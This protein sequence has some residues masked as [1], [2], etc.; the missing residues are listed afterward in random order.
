[1][2]IVSLL[3][4]A[5]AFLFALAAMLQQR[6]A[7]QVVSATS[8]EA[9]IPAALAGIGP[10]MRTL[11]RT[12]TWLLGWVTNLAGFATQAT[13]LHLGSVAA[14]QPWMSTQL[15][16][17]LPLSSADQRRWPRK[18]DWVFALTICAGLVV[19][20]AVEGSTPLEGEARRPR[21][22]LASL[23]AVGGIALLIAA[24]RKAP[25]RT[26]SLLV[27]I[28]AGLCFAMTAVFI[29]LTTEDLIGRGV[30]AT[31]LDWPGYC[32]A[33]SAVGGLMLEQVA[34]AGGPLPWAVAAMSVTNPVASFAIGLL[35]FGVEIP[36]TAWSWAG[37]AVA[38]ALIVAGISGL[39][40]SPMVRTMYDAD[41]GPDAVDGTAPHRGP[42][43]T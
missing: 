2:I 26:A 10:L 7:R 11:L 36:D 27:A 6:A 15:L 17:A 39:A 24:S 19:L 34:F 28:G 13:G 8:Q 1:V 40:H 35:A 43:T 4:L 3:G 37:I 31:A 42:M 30:A 21:V 20:V 9:L 33:I 16:F 25:A 18:R 23:C 22:I 38:G 12:R 32:L 14:V 29:K 5:A 41:T